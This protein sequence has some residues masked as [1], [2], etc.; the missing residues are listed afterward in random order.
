M[1]EPDAAALRQI[2]KRQDGVIS[3]RQVLDCGFTPDDIRRWRRRRE[4][5]TIFPGVYI[6]HTGPLT[7]MQRAWAA[8]LDAHPAALG[9][10]SAVAAIDPARR[11]PGPIQLAVAVDRRVTHRPGVVVRYCAGLE[12]RVLW[13]TAPPRIRLEE[14][15]L[16][17]AAAAPDELE[18]V[19]MLTDAVGGRL[20]TA[21]RLLG[22][23]NR[24][25]RIRR[26]RLLAE[27]LVDIRD[28]A[29]SV[30]EREYLARVERPHRLPRPQRQA[31]TTVG[32]PG[33]RDLDYPG[34]GVVIELDG[35]GVHSSARARD[36]DLERDLDAA[37]GAE[38]LTLRLGW[39][40]VFGRPCT[41]AAKIG[42]LLRGRG[43]AGTITDC[44]VCSDATLR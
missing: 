44:P 7:W 17:A 20:T 6:N 30:L 16:D 19:G 39:G 26:R 29:C 11:T 22:A 13:Q 25:G 36:L 42:R 27:M 18:A 4:W 5:S 24:R 28:G 32:R 33:F 40:Q 2:L 1:S 43:W 15:L 38:R 3:R 23:L 14:A 31:P 9:G 8:V 37:V 21:D 35:R 34:Y 12:Q 41:T 10:E